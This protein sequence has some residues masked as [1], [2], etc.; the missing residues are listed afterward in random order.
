VTAARRLRRKLDE[1]YERLAALAA[2][3]IPEERRLPLAAV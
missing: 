1:R 3:E 2:A